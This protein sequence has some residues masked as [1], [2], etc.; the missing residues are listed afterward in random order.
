M[1]VLNLIG[2]AEFANGQRY[3]IL[4]NAAGK[5]I[6]LDRRTGNETHAGTPDAAWR[7]IRYMAR[8][9]QATE[10]TPAVEVS[11]DY[12]DTLT[13]GPAIGRYA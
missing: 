11:K 9:G 13:L 1:K 10:R 5:C 8:I 7:A 4:Q 12:V 6:V 2:S 3:D